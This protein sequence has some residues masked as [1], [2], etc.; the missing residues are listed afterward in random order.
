MVSFRGRVETEPSRRASS[1]GILLMADQDEYPLPLMA[2]GR[3]SGALNPV[4]SI[5]I[6]SLRTCPGVCRRDTQSP[7]RHGRQ[8]R[9]VGV[10]HLSSQDVRIGSAASVSRS[11]VAV[12]HGFLL[13]RL[14]VR[15]AR[16][17][18]IRTETI[19]QQ[20]PMQGTISRHA[21]GPGVMPNLVFPVWGGLTEKM[22]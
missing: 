1:N 22:C 13:L 5:T 19:L 10:Q 11:V 12:P 17:A 16:D 20:H 2:T 15:S 9:M 14:V 8:R 18:L 21:F 3:I 7:S 6:C 4:R